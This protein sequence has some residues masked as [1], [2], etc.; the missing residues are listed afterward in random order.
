MIEQRLTELEQRLAAVEQHRC[1]AER[2]GKGLVALAVL[3]T[4]LALALT[5]EQ[6]GCTASAHSPPPVLA[7]S[8]R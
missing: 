2:W 8:P 1:Q 7:A 5:A 4:A 6:N 3:A